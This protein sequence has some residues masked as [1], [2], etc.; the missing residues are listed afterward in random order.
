[1]AT[2]PSTPT[3]GTVVTLRKSKRGRYHLVSH[4]KLRNNLLA[5]VGY[6]ELANAG[7]FAANVWND[8]PVPRHAM[9]LMAIG[10][11]IALLV[12]L[13]A[14]RDFYLSWKNVS[15]LR[16]ERNALRSHPA[17]SQ[18]EICV[19]GVNFRELGT[20][21][22]DRVLMDVLLGI[23]ALLVGAGTIM[24]IWGA[25][26]E[27][28]KTSNL[29]SGFLGNSLAAFFGIVNAV[30]SGYLVYRF[31][32]RCT[33]C[34]HNPAVDALRPKLQTR[35]RRL[36]W[37]SAI[38]GVNGLV[39]GMAS[40]VTARMWWGYVV[41]IPCVVVMIAGNLYWRKKLGYDRRVSMD[42]FETVLDRE[43]DIGNDVACDQ[44]LDSLAAVTEALGRLQYM[45]EVGD[46]DNVI[47]YIQENDMVEAFCVWLAEKWPAYRIFDASEPFI[48][49]ASED[50]KNGSEEERSRITSECRA[51]LQTQ[52]RVILDHRERYLLELIGEHMWIKQKID[53]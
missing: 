5:G 32:V 41:L 13:V 25:D 52:G 7:D 36:Q 34:L 45:A 19:L 33:A 44:I 38:N 22:I 16:S 12:S 47:Q 8:I 11:P 39:A 43:K 9:I 29:L 53:A 35:F 31:H 28:F 2:T 10:G 17:P 14:A 6:L 18:R 30:W 46:I 27:I 20:E 23:G 48:C 1:M 51:F 26:P 49:I 15:I 4:A 40:M 21:L 37:H 42:L 50:L 3:S 24:A